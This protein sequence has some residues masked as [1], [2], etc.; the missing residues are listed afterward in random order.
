MVIHKLNMREGTSCPGHVYWD[1]ARTSP[2]GGDLLQRHC[3]Q[4]ADGWEEE[5]DDD[6]EGGDAAVTCTK[7]NF[8]V[9]QW[10]S[11]CTWPMPKTEVLHLK[12]QYNWSYIFC[13]GIRS[14]WCAVKRSAWTMAYQ[15]RRQRGG[16][17]GLAPVGNSAPPQPGSIKLYRR[18][19]WY[20]THYQLSN[21]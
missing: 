10:H 11:L 18:R 9:T 6:D 7:L 4:W 13:F 2:V 19:R 5:D 21:P 1:V 15:R 16:G 3:E 14:I 20:C 12:L 8:L 17:R